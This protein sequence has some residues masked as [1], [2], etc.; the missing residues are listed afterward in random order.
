[1]T[2]TSVH[3]GAASL[4]STRDRRG[5]DRATTLLLSTATGLSVASLYYAQ[6]LLEDIR[7]ALHLSTSGAGL[8]VTITQIGYALSL[9]FLV[10]LGDLLERRRLVTAMCLLSAVAL[11]AVGVAPNAGLLYL[12][13]AVVG[14]FSTTAQMLV[15]FAAGLAAPEARG[16]VVGTVMSGLLLGILLARTAAGYL[17][18]LG[19]W[20]LV[21][22][23]AAGLMVLLAGALRARLPLAPPTSDLRYGALLRS[24]LSLLREEP[25]LRLRALYGALTFAGFSVLWTPISL[26]LAGNPYHFA[27]DIIGLFGLAGVAGAVAAGLAGR[28]ADRGGAR[29]VTGLCGLLLTV[30]WLPMGFGQHSLI[31]LIVGIIG[32]DLACQAMHITNQSEIY[33]LRPEARSRLTSA[34]MTCY[35]SGGVVG[36]SLASLAYADYGWDGVSVLGA[37]IGAC[38]CLIWLFGLRKAR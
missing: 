23:V 33:R 11:T 35:F 28:L 38:V 15:A 26:M 20:R 16:K 32:Y 19:G 22:W 14:L 37:A 17:A 5:L 36:S 21:F 1:M 13:S 29:A 10:P 31:A 8:V 30:M 3:A 34:Y 7:A 6:P 4:P 27:P 25:V 9:L 2:S 12:F 24:V 18:E